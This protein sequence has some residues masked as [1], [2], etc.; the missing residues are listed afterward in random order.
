MLDAGRAGR[1]VPLLLALV[2][3]LAGCATATSP[4]TV[5]GPSSTSPSPT[6]PSPASPSPASPSPTSTSSPVGERCNGIRYDDV[7]GPRPDLS[8]PPLR[9]TKVSRAICAGYWAPHLD[10][11][12]TPQ[13]LEISGTTAY[14]GG[15]RWSRDVSTRPCQI[16]VIDTRTGRTTAFV[17]KF[18]APVYGPKPTYCRHA[19]GMELTRDGLWVAEL[20]RLW[21]LDPAK[22]GK[23]DPVIRV[24]KLDRTVR[25]ATV[26]VSGRRIGFGSFRAARP[27]K[28]VWFDLAD[29]LA[30]RRTRLDRSF[31]DAVR[32]VPTRLQGITSTA[33][34]LWATSSSSHCAELRAPGRG[35]VAFVHGAED[36]EVVGRYLWTV[37]EAG[38][39]AYLHGRD[40]IVPSLVRLDTAKVLAGKRHTCGW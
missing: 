10:D 2:L 35:P 27:G 40:P 34:G 24:W 7:L 25:G 33:G 22:L 19:G 1:Q 21:L 38:V 28:L 11:Y 5:A 12:F 37:S 26:L 31:A 4:G 29:V 32:R 20:Q 39:K 16:A 8:G 14:V 30:P 6:S 13:S 23:G 3:V 15:Y 18:Q 9:V 36:L 17:A